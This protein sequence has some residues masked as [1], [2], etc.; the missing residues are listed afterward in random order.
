MIR[1]P[2][3]VRAYGSRTRARG[4]PFARRAAHRARGLA[5]MSE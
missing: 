2:F 4:E 5:L 3:A 1:R